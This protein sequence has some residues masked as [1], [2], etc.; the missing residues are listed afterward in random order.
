MFSVERQI[1]AYTKIKMLVKQENWSQPVKSSKWIM[2][3]MWARNSAFSWADD[4][5]NIKKQRK[6]YMDYWCFGFYCFWTHG[7][8]HLSSLKNAG[9]GKVEQP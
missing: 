6:Q 4:N 3:Y 9:H 1:W 2:Y 7:M 8:A 5:L